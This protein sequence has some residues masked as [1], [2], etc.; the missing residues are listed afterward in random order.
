MVILLLQLKLEMLKESAELHLPLQ[1]TLNVKRSKDILLLNID[2]QL[3][4]LTHYKKFNFETSKPSGL[5]AKLFIV[6][7]NKYNDIWRSLSFI[8]S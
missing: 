6:V 4:C 5:W 3:I 2:V 8:I 1:F 7:H